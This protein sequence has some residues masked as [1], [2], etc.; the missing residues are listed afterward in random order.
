MLYSKNKFFL[1]LAKLRLENIYPTRQKHRVTFPTL[2]SMFIFS[3]KHLTMHIISK[4]RI[5]AKKLIMQ[6][7]SYSPYVEILHYIFQRFTK[8]TKQYLTM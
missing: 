7:S 8:N 1:V 3:D 6:I 2:L 4:E 5:S